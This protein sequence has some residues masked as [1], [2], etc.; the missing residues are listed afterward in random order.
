MT[1]TNLQFGLW[2]SPITPGSL[3]QGISFSDLGWDVGGA[4]VWREG[5]SDRGVLVVLPPGGEAERDLNSDF[6]TRAGVGYGGGDFGVGDGNVFFVEAS[7]KR[8]YSQPLSAGSPRPVTPAFG[9][10]ASP[11]LSPD[12]NW[13]LYVHTYEGQDALALIDVQGSAWPI[14]LAAGKDFYMQPA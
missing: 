2:P 10:A 5:R 8:I 3:S 6:S 11:K 4:L 9:A 7:S 14:R 1:K 12:G 13:L